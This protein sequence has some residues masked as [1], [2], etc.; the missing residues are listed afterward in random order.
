MLRLKKCFFI[1]E[2]M[3]C[4]GYDVL[5]GKILLSTKKFNDVKDFLV[6]V[7]L[8]EVRIFVQFCNFYA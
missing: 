6:P 3:K 4:L 5:E 7:T 2:E 1:L 8:R